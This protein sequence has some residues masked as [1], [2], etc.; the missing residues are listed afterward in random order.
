LKQQKPPCGPADSYRNPIAIDVPG[1][2]D[3]SGWKQARPFCIFMRLEPYGWDMKH[4]RDR[5]QSGLTPASLLAIV[6]ALVLCGVLTQWEEVVV[7]MNSFY[8]EHSVPLP[9]VTVLILFTVL[10]ALVWRLGR[11]RLLSRAELL[12][13]LYAMLIAIP[14]ITQ[15]FWHRYLSVTA[16]LPREPKKFGYLSTYSDDLWPHGANLVEEGFGPEGAKLWQ[17]QGNVRIEQ[18][19]LD[20]AGQVP[21]LVLENA[22]EGQNSYARFRIPRRADQERLWQINEPFLFSVQ[23][24]TGQ[25]PKFELPSSATK[26]YGRLVDAQS[27]ATAVAFNWNEISSYTAL[28]KDGFLLAGT[29]NVRIPPEFEA[30]ALWL[31]LGLQGQGRVVMRTPKFFSMDAIESAFVGKQIITQAEYDALPPAA[32]G[33]KIVRPDSLLSWDGLKFLFKGYIPVGQWIGPV[34][35][36]TALVVILLTAA[37]ALNVLLRKQWMENERY[38]MPLSKIPMSLLG[39]QGYND[40]NPEVFHSGQMPPVWKNRAMWIGLALSAFWMILRAW[41]YYNP[42]VPNLSLQVK[43][44]PYFDDPSYGQMFDKNTA[45]TVSAIFLSIAMFMELS[46][47]FSIAAGYWIYRSMF[48]LGESTGWSELTNYP[49]PQQTQTGAFL[50]YAFLIVVFTRKYLWGVIKASFTGDREAWKGEL[51][52][53]PIAIGVLALCLVLSLVWAWAYGISLG[54]MFSLFAFLLIV[55]LIASKIRTEAGM[56]FSYIGPINASII[57]LMMGGVTVFGPSSLIFGVII[58]FMV[59]GTPFF[60]IPG[61][62]L[63]LVE[64]GRRFRIKRSHI[65][66]TV[67]LG[68]VGGMGVGAWVFLSNTYSLGGQQMPYQWPWMQQ[69][70]E[71][72]LVQQQFDQQTASYRQEMAE[73]GAPDQEG[74]EASGSEQSDDAGGMQPKHWAYVIGGLLTGAVAILR[75]MFAGFWF[76][77]VGILFS[78]THMAQLIWGSCLVAWFLRVLV[79]RFG[80]AATVRR[81]LQPFFVGVFVGAVIGSGLVAIHSAYLMEQGMAEVFRWDQAGVIP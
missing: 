78:A 48:W 2:S 42:N 25:P 52:P 60:L 9:A 27:G 6:L 70:R 3:D 45:F 61:A 10:G 40:P 35:R 47:L 71:Y 39:S 13:V 30:D 57:L 33:N 36:W 41:S 23:V 46:I 19:Q 79:L 51:M 24:R 29:P 32:R 62:Q 15:G 8:A 76:H 58:G 81:K 21:V 73:Q 65:L 5:N 12:C 55:A 80:G 43:L 66:A 1:I 11:M 20:H 49:F 38:L 37:L 77:P 68:I 44:L 56:P 75:Q 22:E 74:A 53:Y 64:Y 26:Y 28:Q 34:L 50:V 17:T 72:A 4:N 18:M 16:T 31:E 67:F 69:N 59:G 63:E 14:L 7:G 54:G